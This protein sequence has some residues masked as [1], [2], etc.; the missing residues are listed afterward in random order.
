MKKQIK[1][2][3]VKPSEENAIKHL[4]E[5]KNALEDGW[6]LVNQASTQEAVIYILFKIPE[7]L[8]KKAQL[9]NAFQ[10]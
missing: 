10:K 4:E 7:E 9:A 6:T 5:M 1:I 2:F 3:L 8:L